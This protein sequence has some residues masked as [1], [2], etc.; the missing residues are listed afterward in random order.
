MGGTGKLVGIQGMAR[1]LTTADP[2][3]GVTRIPRMTR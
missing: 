2:K 1:T 3:A